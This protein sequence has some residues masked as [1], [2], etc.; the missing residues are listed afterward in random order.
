MKKL[1]DYSNQ[2]VFVCY[3]VGAGG[4]STSVKI[5]SIESCSQLTCYVTEES[6]T[7]ITNEF[8]QKIFLK[9][10]GSFDEKV[11][12]AQKILQNSA[13]PK[14]I[15]IVPSHWDYS[16]YSNHTEFENSRFIRIISPSKEILENN[17]NEK[18]YNSKFKTLSEL[19]GFCLIFVN[20]DILSL[21]LK[22]K[23]INMQ[24][25]IGEIKQEL[26]NM[27]NSKQG[28]MID[29]FR[30]I[31]KHDSILNIDYNSFSK[32]QSMIKEFLNRI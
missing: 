20:K 28:C 22:N 19:I 7:I 26:V 8:F 6:R 12:I 11:Q 25:T 14:K 21:L 18:I 13:I 15:L 5:S 27:P 32:N 30:S 31:V 2:F 1:K 23:K 9:I 10:T 3:D 17:T 4:E 29:S 24:M 16:F